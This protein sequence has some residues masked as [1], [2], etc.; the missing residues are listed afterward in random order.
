VK[1]AVPINRPLPKW[2]RPAA[3]KVWGFQ[4]LL[5]VVVG[6]DG[7]VADASIVKSIHPAYDRL[8]MNAAKDWRFSPAS[9]EGRPV[10][11]RMMYSVVVP[12]P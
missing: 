9:I 3:L 5:A 8:L 7:T 4:G 6:E 12:A 11:F 1:P 10:K 2:E